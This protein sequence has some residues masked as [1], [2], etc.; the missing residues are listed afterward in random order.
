M[1]T[2][3]SCP[4]TYS[5]MGRGGRTRAMTA[6]MKTGWPSRIC[7]LAAPAVSQAVLVEKGLPFFSPPP[8][9]TPGGCP[10]KS[11]RVLAF[12]V[13]I[14]AEKGGGWCL[15]VESDS[16]IKYTICVKNYSFWCACSIHPLPV[17]LQY[18]TFSQLFFLLCFFF[19]SF[20]ALHIDVTVLVVLFLSFL[21][22]NPS[23]SPVN[24]CLID[25]Q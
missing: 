3:P 10:T 22:S 24:A 8:E 20:S 18:A 13:L 16:K 1:S 19:S 23:F 4:V 25:R 5:L 7:R 12:S 11:R 15:W 14:P 6:E 17:H 9:P 21:F 2:F